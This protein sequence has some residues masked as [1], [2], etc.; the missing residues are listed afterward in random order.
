M[1]TSASSTQVGNSR[2]ESTHGERMRWV[3]LLRG[4][5]VG[6]ITI[7]SADLRAVFED[8]GAEDV[9]TVLASGNVLFTA[10]GA[11]AL[12]KARIQDALRERFGYDAWIIL[13]TADELAQ[14]A[15]SFPFDAQDAARQPY[16]VFCAD[17]Q[18]QVRVWEAVGALDGDDER[19]VPGS[20]V[21]YWHARIG[22]STDSPVARVLARAAFKSGTTTRNLRT[23]DKMLT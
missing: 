2:G 10:P 8:L 1:T 16:V 23:V 4:V 22:T 6:G 17:A 3:A 19:V 18:T 7:R 14:V 5:N 13:V 12:W 21:V 20:G 15:A 11:R 9:R